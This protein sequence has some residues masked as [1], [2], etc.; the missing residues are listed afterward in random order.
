MQQRPSIP[1]TCPS[2]LRTLIQACWADAPATRPSFHAVLAQLRCMQAVLE[3]SCP[4]RLAPAESSASDLSE[5]L[6]NAV[7]AGAEG[8]GARAGGTQTAEAMQ[9]QSSFGSRVLHSYASSMVRSAPGSP[10]APNVE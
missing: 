5:G 6:A 2:E 1:E 3:A 10:A 9:T 8:V 4:P 7:D